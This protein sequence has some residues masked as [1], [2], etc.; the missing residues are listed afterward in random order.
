MIQNI[1]PNRIVHKREPRTLDDLERFGK[2][3]WS[4][5]PVSLFKNIIRR[6]RRSCAVLSALWRAFQKNTLI[7]ENTTHV[8]G[9]FSLHFG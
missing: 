1:F 9:T 5:I 2:E 8:K 3:E 4:Q 7:Y 6:Y